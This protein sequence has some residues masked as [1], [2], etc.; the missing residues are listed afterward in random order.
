[1]A[2]RR[3]R[4]LKYSNISSE[5]MIRKSKQA[6]AFPIMPKAAQRYARQSRGKETKLEMV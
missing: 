1:M 4:Q 5:S 3:E 2:R 6:V